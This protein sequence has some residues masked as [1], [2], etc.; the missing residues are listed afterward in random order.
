MRDAGFLF[1]GDFRLPSILNRLDFHPH[2]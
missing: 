1:G 2:L